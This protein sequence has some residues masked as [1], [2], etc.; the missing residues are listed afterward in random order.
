MV[1]HTTGGYRA[2]RTYQTGRSTAI[3]VRRYASFFQWCSF[4]ASLALSVPIAFLREL[5]RGNQAAALAKW[6][7]AWAGLRVPLAA[8]PRWEPSEEAA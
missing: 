6:R 2:G 4:L 3:F 1:S 8:P 7:G 5:P